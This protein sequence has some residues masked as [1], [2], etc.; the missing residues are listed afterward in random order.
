MKKIFVATIAVFCLGGCGFLDDANDKAE[1]ASKPV[2]IVA[3][4]ID[5]AEAVV[6]SLENVS[7]QKLPENVVVKGENAA[8]KIHTIAQTGAGIA[9]ALG[10][11]GIGTLLAALAALAGGAGSFFHRRRAQEI[12]VAASRAA[13]KVGGG[14]KAIMEEAAK[15]GVSDIVNSVYR[16]RKGE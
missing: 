15:L 14:G 5:E 9:T 6:K 1:K 8:E 2:V 4:S 3:K 16:E 11:P 13:D 12:A 10:Q 7:G